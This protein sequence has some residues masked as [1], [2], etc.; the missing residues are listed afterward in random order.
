VRALST[1]AEEATSRGVLRHRF[2]G[3]SP[4]YNIAPTQPVPVIRQHPKEPR[5]ELS[6]VRWG[7]IPS[8][9]KDSSAAARMIN[10]RSETATKKPAFR[11]RRHDANHSALSKKARGAG[12]RGRHSPDTR[13]ANY[14]GQQWA[15]AKWIFPSARITPSSRLPYFSRAC[16]I[17]HGTRNTWSAC[18]PYTNPLWGRDLDNDVTRS[19]SF[20]GLV[21]SPLATLS[22]FTSDTFRIPRSIPL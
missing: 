4:R 19:N 6:L 1:V 10:A 7:L 16:K 13:L 21:L 11:G 15:N 3:R 20:D 22:I 14:K 2:W 12:S 18:G 17:D 9:A 5:R 8:W